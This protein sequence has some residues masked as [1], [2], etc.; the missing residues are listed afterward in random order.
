MLPRL[1][2]PDETLLLYSGA[3]GRAVLAELDTSGSTAL[4]A[5]GPVY[6]ASLPYARLIVTAWPGQRTEDRDRVDSVAFLRGVPSIGLDLAPTRITCG[7]LVRPGQTACFSCYQR[8]RLQHGRRA[9]EV[10]ALADALDEGFGFADVAIAVGLLG[11]ALIELSSPVEGIGGTVRAFDLI[12]GGASRHGTV[13]VDRCP[14]CS[15][16]FSTHRDPVAALSA[17]DH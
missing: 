2:L 8:R 6:T 4:P 17:L 7:P 15:Q 12:H 13:A 5:D 3:F 10:A 16:R 1:H 14:R 11:E 9:T